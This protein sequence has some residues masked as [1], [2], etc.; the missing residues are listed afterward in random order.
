VDGGKSWADAEL[1]EPVLSKAL[2]AF[3][4]PWRWDG[5]EAV[6]QSRCTD[7][8]GYLQPTREEL[9]AVRGL[10]SGYHYNAVKQWKVKADGRVVNV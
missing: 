6:I 2:T 10:H 5:G 8:T 3:R 7:E 4:F 9:I 1:Q